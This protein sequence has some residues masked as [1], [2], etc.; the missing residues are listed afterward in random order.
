MKRRTRVLVA[1]VAGV[2]LAVGITG[3]AFAY[4]PRWGGSTPEVDN[5]LTT[6]PV[7]DTYGPLATAPVQDTLTDWT[8]PCGA[9]AM[10]PMFGGYYGMGMY[11]QWDTLSE[12]LGLTPEEI[13]QQYIEG[14][15]L[16]EI[17]E[18]QG[19][20]EEQVV[21][22]IVAERAEVLQQQVEAGIITQEQADA[23]LERM[24]EHVPD[25]LDSTM[26]GPGAGAGFGQGAGG[27]GPGYGGMMG[28]GS[29]GIGAGQGGYGG[30][31]GGGQGT[32]NGQAGYGGMMG[33]GMMGGGWGGYR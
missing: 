26:V 28:G 16:L 15:T 4:G 32:G 19:V 33:G 12:I 14:K 7:Q 9:G 11:G 21:D 25:M 31:M 17:A 29:Q 6:V 2:A 3:A 20:S 1:T 5:A 24:E 23:M 18:A 27:V 30:M 13:Q 10:G 8:H 22:A